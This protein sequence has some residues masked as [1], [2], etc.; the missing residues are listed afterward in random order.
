MTGDCARH[1]AVV[2]FFRALS[3]NYRHKTAN[4][5]AKSVDTELQ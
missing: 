5:L 1:D 3:R 4:L 2:S